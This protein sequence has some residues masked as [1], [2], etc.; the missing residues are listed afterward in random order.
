MR[1]PLPEQRIVRG[2][3]DATISHQFTDADGDAATPSGTVTVSVTRSDGTAVTVGA[4]AG[5]STAPRTVTVGV[6]ELSVVDQLTAVW[7]VGAVAVATDIIDVVGGTIGSLAQIEA[8]E[9]TLAGKTA[10]KVKDAR[11][12]AESRFIDTQHRSPVT[13]LTVERFNGTGHRWLNGQ[14]PDLV[15]V[16]WARVYSSPTAFTELTADQIAAINTPDELARFERSDTCWPCGRNNIEIA[17]VFGMTE[18]PTGLRRAF[19]RAVRVECNS[20]TTGVP[21]RS[22]T[23]ASAD[24]I[25]FGQAR[26]GVKGAAYGIDE[27]DAVWNDYRD[28]RPAIA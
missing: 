6:A 17:Y 26:P 18:L 25:N 8:V 12:A 14:W 20:P 16:R 10:A 1:T 2:A 13:R 27:I 11:S 21:E 24:G 9:T 19:Y 7:S 23:W 5:A 3:S 22:T 28:P 15:E 4:V